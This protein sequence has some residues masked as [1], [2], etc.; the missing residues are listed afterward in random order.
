MG[1]R[2]TP[3]FDSA[4]GESSSVCCQCDRKLKEDCVECGQCQSWTCFKCVAPG[5]S[6]KNVESFLENSGIHFSCQSCVK[7]TIPSDGVVENLRKE[8]RELRA[9][10]EVLSKKF[11]ALQLTPGAPPTV[12]SPVPSLFEPQ[13]QRLIMELVPVITKAVLEA[14][15]EQMERKEKRRNLVLVGLP[16][17]RNFDLDED[18]NCED[19]SKLVEVCQAVGINEKALVKNFRDGRKNGFDGKRQNRI[20]KLVF[21]NG[22]ARHKFLVEAND[23]LKEDNSFAR[24]KFTPFV[25]IDQT[26][27]QRQLDAQLRKELKDRREAGEHNLIIRK[28]AIV[29]RSRP[30]DPKKPRPRETASPTPSNPVIN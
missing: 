23:I 14:V 8:N 27:K 20:V 12:A 4:T 26:Y 28:G 3:T 30:V 21:E 10:V 13:L 25:R 17:N 22:D 15:E 1:M 6:V 5:L 11:D 9:Q 16:E 19:K 2:R 18:Q 7:N 24:L 29:E